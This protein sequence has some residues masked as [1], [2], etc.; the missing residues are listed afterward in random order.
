MRIGLDLSIAAFNA[1]GNARYAAGLLA[2]LQAEGSA[3]LVP[4]ALPHALRATA[5]GARRKALVTYWELVYAP[6]VLPLRARR[7]QLDLLHCPLPLPV[8]DPGCPLVVTVLDAIPA[9]YPQ[10]FGRVMGLRLRR[11]LR[12]GVVAADSL[13]TISQR[14]ADDV[15][16]LFPGLA[17]PIYPVYLGSFLEGGPPPAPPAGP[18]YLLSVGTLEPRKNLARTL[19]AYALLAQ[20]RPRAPR[21]VVVGGQGWGGEDV[22]AVARRLGVGER[23]ELAGFVSDERLRALYAGAALLVYPSLYEGFGFPVLEAMGMGCPVVASSTSSLPE[24]AGRAA[25]LVDPTDPDQIAAAM[26]RILDAPDLARQLREAGLRRARAFS[27]GR[28]ARETLAAYRATLGRVGQP[29]G[30]RR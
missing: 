17:A 16:C 13:L 27:W 7:H 14:T 4:L 1:A 25:L 30:Q 28:C 18:P 2:A 15:R 5:G 22:A 26:S 11:W 12:R 19:E 6:V 20:A 3:E 9:L 24:V 23:V 8:G 29:Q 10:W 21:L